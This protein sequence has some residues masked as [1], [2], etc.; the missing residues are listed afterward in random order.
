MA[1][2]GDSFLLCMAEGIEMPLQLS[3]HVMTWFANLYAILLVL[4]LWY[5]ANVFVYTLGTL[6]EEAML[7]I[8][9]FALQR[10]RLSLGSRSCRTQGAGLA[11]VFIFLALPLAFLFGY[12]LNFQVYVLR[13]DVILASAAL[14]SLALEVCL[15]AIYGIGVAEG[16]A[17]RALIGIGLV[18]ALATVFVMAGF[19]GSIEKRSF[20]GN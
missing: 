20:L 13:L 10:I 11:A 16:V 12:H 5:K 9:I 19:H 1:S 17:E 15:L 6:I 8:L 2:P 4:L 3:M 14:T 18:A 7:L